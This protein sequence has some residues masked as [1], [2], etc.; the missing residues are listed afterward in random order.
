MHGPCAW[1]KCRTWC[2]LSAA[3]CQPLLPLWLKSRLRS[4][5]TI[6]DNVLLLFSTEFD[7]PITEDLMRACRI[8]SALLKYGYIEKLN[9]C[10]ALCY[11][12]HTVLIITPFSPVAV[13]TYI[14]TSSVGGSLLSAPSPT[15]VICRF[16]ESW[17]L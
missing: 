10:Q 12:L 3:A 2:R 14:P 8:P 17:P 6:G 13:P 16:L 11:I 5:A 15:F 4:E 9:L 7:P 1:P